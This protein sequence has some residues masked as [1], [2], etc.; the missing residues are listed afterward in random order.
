[1]T[2]RRSERRPSTMSE[3]ILERAGRAPDAVPETPVSGASKAS[4]PPRPGS[5]PR[6]A[7]D[8]GA[9]GAGRDR[10]GR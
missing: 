9:D 1:M 5:G 8:A 3:E 10:S 7:R 6:R 2:E 4:I